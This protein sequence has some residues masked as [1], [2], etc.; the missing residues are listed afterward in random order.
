ML[1]N[2]L[3]AHPMHHPAHHP[4]HL[5]GHIPR[6]ILHTFPHTYLGTIP[7]TYP[8]TILC[9]YPHTYP[10]ATRAPSCSPTCAP[11][12]TPTWASSYALTCVP[13]RAPTPFCAPT[14]PPPTNFSEAESGMHLPIAVCWARQ[15]Q[16]AF[17][18]KPPLLST[19]TNPFAPPVISA[20][21]AAFC[22][23]PQPY[24]FNGL[25]GA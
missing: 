24:V 14:P 23:L 10:A 16:A 7:R 9:T 19:P 5:L 1:P 22:E 18:G 8:C 12:R 13:S 21:S 15:D 3:G 2:V 20:T 25:M 11:S 17:P 4:A 6:T